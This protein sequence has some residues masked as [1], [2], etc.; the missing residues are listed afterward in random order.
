[1]FNFLCSEV[2]IIL[3]CLHLPRQQNSQYFCLLVGQECAWKQ[4]QERS[5]KRVKL[6][7][8]TRERN[9]KICHTRSTDVCGPHASNKGTSLVPQQFSHWFAS[10]ESWHYFFQF[11]FFSLTLQRGD[12]LVCPPGESLENMLILQDALND[13]R[14]HHSDSQVS[15][16]SPQGTKSFGCSPP[17]MGCAQPSIIPNPAASASVSKITSL[18]IDDVSQNAFHKDVFPLNPVSLS[19]RA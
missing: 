2:K 9:E 12:Q 1:M 15:S 3:L 5:G 10:E 16:P 6:E 4:S 7:S 14:S 17:N 19:I 11:L 8:E 18:V 13:E